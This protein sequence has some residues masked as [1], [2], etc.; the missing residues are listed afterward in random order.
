M[1]TRARPFLR[2]KVNPFD[3]QVPAASFDPLNKGAA[4]A[5]AAAG[6]GYANGGAVSGWAGGEEDSAAV[7]R[8]GMQFEVRPGK[9]K[10]QRERESHRGLL[11]SLL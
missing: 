9:T 5:G 1:L 8:L 11:L 6:G 7:L 4:G 2:E 10:R 3:A